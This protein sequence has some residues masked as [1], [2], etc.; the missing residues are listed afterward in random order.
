MDTPL[1]L[2]EALKQQAENKIFTLKKALL[3][4]AHLLQDHNNFDDKGR[5]YP[6]DKPIFG[7]NDATITL[8][9]L[10]AAKRELLS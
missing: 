1:S 7:I 4:F 9:D 3:P 2:A 5:P 8:G 6:D 10:R